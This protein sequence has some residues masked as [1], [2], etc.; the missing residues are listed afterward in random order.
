MTTPTAWRCEQAGW[1]QILA[2]LLAGRSLSPAQARWAMTEIMTGEA[3]SAQVAGFAVALRAKGA[4]PAEVAALAEV[5]LEFATP[6]PLPPG[7]CPVVDTCGTGGDRAGT[8]NLSTMAALVVAGTGQVVVKHGNRAASS[9]CG[10]ADVLEELGVRIDL[11]PAGVIRCVESAGMGFCFAPAFHPALRYAAPARRELGV[12]TVFNVLGPLTNPARPA[13]QAVGVADA[14]MAPVVA[15][16]LATRGV[17]ALVFRGEDGLDELSPTGPAR[18]WWVRAGQVEALVVDPARLGLPPARAS[19]LRGGDAPRNA[20]VVREV[21]AGAR[22][23][24]RDAVLLNAA[25][26]LVAL[27]EL[28]RPAVRP[29]VRPA[30]SAAPSGG[31]EV[32]EPGSPGGSQVALEKRLRAGVARAARALDDGA[33]ERVLARLVAASQGEPP[34]R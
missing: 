34:D 7:V 29:A 11:P 15:Q 25:A 8:V 10:T 27:D 24:V 30:G 17:S 21:L 2:D 31:V 28:A 1:P 22:G 18:L 32:D 12:P 33:A 3:T 19:D 4:S 13:A 9:A 16:A 14:G 20:A 6:L 23:S 5:M 26:A